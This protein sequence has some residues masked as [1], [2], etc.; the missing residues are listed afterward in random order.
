MLI[1]EGPCAFNIIVTR[2][3]W[4]LEEQDGTCWGFDNEHYGNR[5]CFVSFILELRKLQCREVKELSGSSKAT[6]GRTGM[7]THTL[8]ECKPAEDTAARAMLSILKGLTRHQ[9]P[10]PSKRS[11]AVPGFLPAL[12]LLSRPVVS[13]T[14]W[15][16][17]LQHARLP[18]PHCLPELAQTLVHWVGGAIQPSHPVAP[19]SSC[20]QFFPSSGSFQMSQLF[21]SS[22]QSVGASA[23]ASVLPKNIQD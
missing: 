21:T 16:H 14:L 7:W 23:S 6:G 19:F 4:I 9:R 3:E 8:C 1:F 5:K 15:P 18:V 20:P 17:G 22:G 13:N 10:A 12:W 11:T 2:S